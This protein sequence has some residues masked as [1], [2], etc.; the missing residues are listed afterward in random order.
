MVA[1][2]T[3][4]IHGA[5]LLSEDVSG[6]ELPAEQATKTPART[7]PNKAMDMGSL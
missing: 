7:A 2:P 4:V 5:T 1:A 3:V 6:P